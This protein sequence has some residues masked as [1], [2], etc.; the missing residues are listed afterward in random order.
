MSKKPSIKREWFLK[1]AEKRWPLA[2]GALTEV[3]KTCL[4]PGCKACASGTKHPV[5]IYT[6]WEQGR[7][8]CLY[9]PRRFVVSLRQAIDNGRRFEKLMTRVG[10]ELIY[11]YRMERDRFKTRK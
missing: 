10:R 6:F 9:V 4:Q 8:R 3:K 7:Q 11:T 2:K 5:W 1:E